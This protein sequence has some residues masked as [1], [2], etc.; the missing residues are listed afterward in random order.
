MISVMKLHLEKPILGYIHACA[1]ENDK[2]WPSR[3]RWLFTPV[4]CFSSS[5]EWEDKFFRGVFNIWKYMRKN[6]VTKPN[7]IEE[8]WQRQPIL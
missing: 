5:K 6:L 8:E 1:P 4:P 2:S 7:L 3:I